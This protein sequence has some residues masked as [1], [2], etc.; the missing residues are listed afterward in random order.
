M[1]ITK[2][3]FKSGTRADISDVLDSPT[4]FP[5]YPAFYYFWAADRRKWNGTPH[6]TDLIKG[7]REAFLLYTA[8]CVID[9]D[10]TAHA[11]GGL[12]KHGKLED[13]F[14]DNSRYTFRAEQ[15]V[16][17]LDI[18]GRL[19][20][21]LLDF[22]QHI[23]YIDDL[24]T[25]GAYK[26]KTY[27]GISTKKEPV[28]DEFGNT[29]YI[30]SG[31]NKGMPKTKNTFVRSAGER[32]NLEYDVQ[33][34]F[35]GH[36]LQEQDPQLKDWKMYLHIFFMI[37]DG[38]MAASKSQGI[39]FNTMREPV[40]IIPKDMLTEHLVPRR[41]ALVD[42]INSGLVPDMCTR[43]ERWDDRKCCLAYCSAFEVCKKLQ[44]I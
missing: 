25:A 35:Y 2:F 19:D 29:V 33:I 13:V 42:S 20:A 12:F 40:N 21:M 4:E 43:K 17:W 22:N 3:E 16:N 10:A 37:R 28:L 34:S 9:L 32:D 11:L 18:D 31:K 39:N 41:K 5:E 44:E 6:I 30:K 24:K 8:D 1:P 14:V 15:K 36:A 7:T 27:S 23:I 26:Y 38:G